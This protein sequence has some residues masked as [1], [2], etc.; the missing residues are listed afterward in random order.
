MTVAPRASATRSP[1]SAP[2]RTST[3]P[4][5]RTPI[6]RAAATAASVL[7]RLWRESKGSSS[8]Y[9]SEPATTTWRSGTASGT[10]PDRSD[11][12]SK[13]TSPPGPNVTTASSSRRYGSSRG[14]SDG[15]TAVAPSRMPT[16]SSLFARATPSSD[17]ICSR[18][19][20]PTFVTTPT[21]GS[22]IAVSS[23]IWPKPRIASSSTSTSVPGGA[24]SSSSGSPIS[25]LKLARLAVTV[26]W[27]PISAAIRSFV[28][29]LP[30]EPVTAMACAPSSRRHARASA[31]SAAAG[32][33]AASTAPPSAAAA[34]SRAQP[35]AASTPHAPARSASAAKRPPSTRSPGSAKNR[36]PGS[37]A[38]E[39]I[40]ARTGPPPRPRAPRTSSAPAAPAIRWSL[41]RLTPGWAPLWRAASSRPGVSRRAPLRR[42][43][44]L[45]ERGARDLDVVERLLAPAGELLPLLVALAG[46]HDDVARLGQLD[47]LG[48][49]RAAVGFAFHVKRSA[50]HAAHDLVDDRLG[51]L[52][53][54]VIR[55]HD[56]VV[57]Q[58]CRDLAHQRALRAVAVAARA[59]H[60]QHA[61][62]SELARRREHLLQRAR[63]VRVVDEHGERLALLDRLDAARHGRDGSQRLGHRC[64]LEPE[65]VA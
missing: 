18:W 58:P 38:R 54:R 16:S 3:R 53:A 19:T 57:C 45:A 40:T 64:E 33:S 32:S 10:R 49:R 8:S 63:L 1:R 29:V 43:A 20:G 30:T 13:W 59:E 4:A 46:D 7:S 56:H 12:P 42:L 44:R 65:R 11:A 5:G 17:C 31:P 28:E 37:I 51:R 6:A 14:S 36:S 25:V 21:S 60:D 34:A 52:R 62:G 2:K 39:S 47:R 24:A 26:R 35:G 55:G 22:Q 15:T 23:A 9:R 41:Q 48:D 27:G 50:A 61:A